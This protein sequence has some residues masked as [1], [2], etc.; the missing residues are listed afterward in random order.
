MIIFKSPRISVTKLRVMLST[1]FIGCIAGSSNPSSSAPSSF[2][3]DQ[4]DKSGYVNFVKHE[5]S[6]LNVTAV[7]TSFVSKSGECG[8]VC[9]KHSKGFSFNFAVN[10]DE[11]GKHVCEILSTDKYN[12]SA[13]FLTNKSGQ[14]HYSIKVS[15][16][17]FMS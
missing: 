6:F 9:S 3:R 2:K 11:N 15:F 1:S 14:S 16:A 5:N 4:I 10:P 8:F 7:M 17:Y 13:K 12:D